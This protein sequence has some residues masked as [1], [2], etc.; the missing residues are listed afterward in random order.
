VPPGPLKETF[1][2]I[3]KGLAESLIP[4]EAG[5]GSWTSTL[6]HLA[7]VPMLSAPCLVAADPPFISAAPTGELIGRHPREPRIRRAKADII[8]LPVRGN[9]DENLDENLDG[10]FIFRLIILNPLLA[11]IASSIQ[12]V[13]SSLSVT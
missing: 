11:F 8:P 13:T 10:N 12:P 9:L 3:W 1:T 2:G 5:P 4:W 7:K 6:D